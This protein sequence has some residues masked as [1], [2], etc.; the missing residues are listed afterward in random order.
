MQTRTGNK[1]DF[2]GVVDNGR[3]DV[4]QEEGWKKK[5][6]DGFLRRRDE[7]EE[8]AQKGKFGPDCS[9]RETD[10]DIDSDIGCQAKGCEL[11]Q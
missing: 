11:L 3:H 5:V 10:I 2:S 4:W 1:G 8:I 9:W 6:A 7:A